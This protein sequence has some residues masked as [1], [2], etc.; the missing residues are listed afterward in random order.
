MS[1]ALLPHARDNGL[2][3]NFQSGYRSINGTETALVKDTNNL[4][5]ADSRLV[6]ILVL[7]DLS[8]AQHN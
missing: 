2:F 5:A 1:T 3:E 8:A 6:S 4:L 7:L